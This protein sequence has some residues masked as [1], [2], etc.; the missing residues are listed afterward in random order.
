M[1][2]KRDAF[3]EQLLDQFAFGFGD[4]LGV[5]DELAAA[6]FTPI[7]LFAVMGMAISFNVQDPAPRATEVVHSRDSLK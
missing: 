5:G 3:Q 2:P 6:S 1:P 7:I 4:V